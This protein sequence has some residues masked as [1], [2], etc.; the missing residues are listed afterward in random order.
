MIFIDLWHFKV[1]KLL[2]YLI[3]I[4]NFG[5][6]SLGKLIF[7]TFFAA[8]FFARCTGCAPDLNGATCTS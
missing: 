1:R 2:K 3:F 8:N 5:F 7:N 4:N 6:L